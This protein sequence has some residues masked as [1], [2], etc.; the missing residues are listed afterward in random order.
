MWSLAGTLISQGLSLAAS[1]V[2]ARFLGKSGFGELGM[3]NSTV[4]VFGMLAGLGLGLTTTRYVAVYRVKDPDR[5]GTIIGL[6]TVVAVIS[7]GLISAGIL[8]FASPLATHVL[9]ESVLAS[10]LKI[11]SLLLL[12]NTLNGVQTGTL[13]GFEAFR[14]IA[15][16]NLV[17]GLA[18]FP[19]MIIGVVEWH[20]R[21]AV[22][23]LVVAAAIGWFANH[24]FLRKRCRA[25]GI[26]LRLAGA[27]RVRSILWEFSLPAVLADIAAGPAVWAANTILVHQNNGYGELGI[28]SAAN[29]WRSAMMFVPNIL[30]QVALPILASLDVGSSDSARSQFS[31][32]FE[33]TQT[34]TLSIVLPL[35]ILVMFYSDFVI[36]FYGSQFSG[37][38]PCLI[39]VAL[40]V[41][42][43]GVSAA[44]GPAIQ[45][46]GRMWTG[47]ALNLIWAVIMLALVWVFA[48]KWGANALAYS[49]AASYIVMAVL[50]FAV[51]RAR[52]ENGAMLRGVG[53]VIFAS[54]AAGLALV[55][56]PAPRHL[57]AIPCFLLCIL[58]TLFSFST[59][60]TRQLLF[61]ALSN[62]TGLRLRN[63]A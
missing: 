32:T 22:W 54:G 1:I 16:A 8:L 62:F 45:A 7:A 21:G 6:T 59:R 25:A 17:R 57:L 4:G 38:V 44:G 2:T 10:E 33:I 51:L 9:N 50:T 23:G 18:Y 53:A 61:S 26:H 5:A 30:L 52:L 14:E 60:H 40:T 41:M 27:W 39:G 47:F 34:L 46:S 12:L 13:S 35:G 49:P 48:P 43:M 24:L 56:P 37:G 42:I 28:F 36:G 11:G 63:T 20:L 55:L 29:Q 19:A 3:I 31:R 58:V 15:Q